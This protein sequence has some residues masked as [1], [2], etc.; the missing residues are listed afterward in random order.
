MRVDRA[1]KEEVR[2]RRKKARGTAGSKNSI[3]RVKS[4]SRSLLEKENLRRGVARCGATFFAVSIRGLLP[5]S[6]SITPVSFTG[7]GRGWTMVLGWCLRLTCRVNAR[8]VV[9]IPISPPPLFDIFSSEYTYTR[10]LQ[11]KNHYSIPVFSKM[12][13]FSLEMIVRFFLGIAWPSPAYNY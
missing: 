1:K 13:S 6:L 7:F 5:P 10:L 11:L 8:I 2:K 12:K 9:T 3:R 4:F